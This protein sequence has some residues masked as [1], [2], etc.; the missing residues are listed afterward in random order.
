MAN[1]QLNELVDYIKKASQAGQS[2]GQ[3]RQILS[4]N[5]WSDAEVDEAFGVLS[6]NKT[7]QEPQQ[8]PQPTQVQQQTASQMQPKP[9]QPLQP[10][11]PEIKIQPLQTQAQPASLPEIKPQAQSKYQP[12]EAIENKKFRRGEHSIFKLFAFLSIILIITAIIGAGVALATRVWD[13]T[14]SPFRPAPDAVISKAWNNLKQVKSENFSS[15]LL[16]SGKDIKSHGVGGIFDITM[17][18]NGGADISDPRNKLVSMQAKFGASGTDD[19]GYKYDLSLSGEIRLIGESLYLKLDNINLG[20]L[21]FFLSMFDIDVSKLEGRWIKFDSKGVYSDV[22]AGQQTQSQK[23]IQDKK[24][25]DIKQLPDNQGSEGKEYHYSISLNRTKLNS[26]LPDIFNF[27]Q[28]YINKNST[29]NFGNFPG[30]YTLDGFKK[31][32]NNTFD[33]I[34]DLSV[35]LFIGKSDMLFHKISFDKGVD[36]SKFDSKASGIIQISYKSEKSG[37]NQPLLISAPNDYENFENVFNEIAGPI[38]KTRQVRSDMT[39]IAGL[40]ALYYSSNKS[41]YSF[42][43]GGYLNG[44][45]KTYGAEIAMLSKD[46]VAQGT[47]WA[48]CFSNVQNYCVSVQLADK[49]WLCATQNGYSLGTTKCTS[50]ATLCK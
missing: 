46:M 28:E 18:V 11:K 37:I 48:N 6:V 19:I 10:Q 14:W 47:G 25:Y 30:E 49:S 43:R 20:E 3:T 24:V 1:S 5:G 35:G 22:I 17:E 45:L 13:P 36:I 8:R 38:I 29:G 41:Y 12:I 33:K 44:F 7:P 2:D 42:C 21:W 40:A 39:Q 26:A 23:D 50:A 34:G 4:K 16:L 15:R 9:L 32:V 31:D 27:L